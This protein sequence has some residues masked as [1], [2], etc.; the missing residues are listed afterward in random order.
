MILTTSSPSIKAALWLM[1]V[2]MAPRL[3]G[4]LP[5]KPIFLT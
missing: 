5:M 1:A 3:P 4:N 2:A